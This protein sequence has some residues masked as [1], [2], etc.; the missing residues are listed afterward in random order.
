[1][2]TAR[3]SHRLHGFHRFYREG[4]SVI[5]YWLCVMRYALCV[6]RYALSVMRYAL[7]LSADGTKPSQPS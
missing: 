5:R 6:M 3:V 1:M 4:L 7:S 2:H